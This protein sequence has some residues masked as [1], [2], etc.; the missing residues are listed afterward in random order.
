MRKRRKSLRTSFKNFNSSLK[1]KMKWSTLMIRILTN[2]AARKELIKL[3]ASQT[4]SLLEREDWIRS[5]RPTKRK[6]SWWTNTWGTSRLSRMPS[7]KSNRLLVS[8]ISKKSWQL[9]SRLKNR[10][11]VFKTTWICSILSSISLKKATSRFS[12]KSKRYKRE[13]TSLRLA[14]KTSSSLLKMRY[15]CSIKKLNKT[16][17]ILSKLRKLSKKFRSTSLLWSICSREADS[18]CVL[19]K[20]WTM[21]MESTSLKTILCSILLS[22]RSIFLLWSPTLPLREMNQMLQS[23]PFHWRNWATKT[24]PKSNGM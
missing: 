6:E 13:E 14:K 2:K 22:S 18:F 24:F 20:K 21:M 17:M 15:Q 16:K 10:I 1:K 8:Q 12:T 9:S 23:A 11:T 7:T 5:L 4:P 3:P 19:L